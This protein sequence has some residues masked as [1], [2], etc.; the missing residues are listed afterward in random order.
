MRFI[1]LFSG[2]KLSKMFLGKT[3][4]HESRCLRCGNQ[5][6][7]LIIPVRARLSWRGCLTQGLL[8]TGTRIT[9][10]QSNLDARLNLMRPSQSRTAAPAKV[11]S[12]M[13]LLYSPDANWDGE[14][15]RAVYLNG[16]V[17][18]SQDF[19]RIVTKLLSTN[20]HIDKLSP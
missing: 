1:L 11:S 14:L 8:N 13:K 6:C 19:S 12:G 7:P 4:I 17:V 16:P 2:F 3:Q 18:R 9:C 5:S 20:G 15:P 10:L